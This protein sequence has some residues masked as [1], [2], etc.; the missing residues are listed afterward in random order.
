MDNILNAVE[1]C[2]K[3]NGQKMQY[4]GRCLDLVWIG[5]GDLFERK[6]RGRTEKVARYSLHIQCPF[7]VENKNNIFVG[8][9]DLFI[10][11]SAEDTVVDLNKRES[12]M[13][14]SKINLFNEKFNNETI[15]NIELS[16]CGDLK[17]YLT[18]INITVFV[19]SSD[20]T[21]AWRL[22]RTNSEDEHL[23]VYGSGICFE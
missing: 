18:N 7:R 20:D 5:F 14:D 9:H 17:I 1:M 16:G 11:A 15:A 21:E 2:K 3:L 23:V 12:T 10:P 6:S 8:S 22:F 13:F 4:I 19:D